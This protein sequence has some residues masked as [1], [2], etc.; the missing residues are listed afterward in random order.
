MAAPLRR[1]GNLRNHL[2][3]IMAGHFLMK[4]ARNKQR[5]PQAASNSGPGSFAGAGLNVP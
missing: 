3:I 2:A 5:E 4:G 1:T